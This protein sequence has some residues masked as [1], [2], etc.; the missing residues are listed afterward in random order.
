MVKVVVLHCGGGIEL[1]QGTVDPVVIVYAIM[2]RF[3]LKRTKTNCYILALESVVC[4]PV[5]QVVAEAGYE[6]TQ[7]L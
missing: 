7:F 1:G 6:K 3:S 4:S 5:V 2:R